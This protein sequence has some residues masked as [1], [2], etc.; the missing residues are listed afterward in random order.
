MKSTK[1]RAAKR[2][3][4]SAAP[5][6]DGAAPA[7]RD[8]PGAAGTPGASIGADLAAGETFFA[9]DQGLSDTPGA[10]GSHGAAIGAYLEARE[11]FLAAD[12]ALSTLLRIIQ[13]VAGHLADK[14]ERGRLIFH[15]TGIGLPW[16]QGA[17]LYA[18]PIMPG[19]WPDAARLQ[20]ALADWHAA[21]AGTRSAW[22]ALPPPFAAA[23]P[24]P[25]APLRT[26]VLPG[27]VTI[28]CL[29]DRPPRQITAIEE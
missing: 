1:Q 10:A 19:D 24:A 18:I 14:T 23:L 29:D 6:S 5:G 22:R 2:P 21:H 15:G 27:A 9:A 25:P 16:P 26:D 3:A 7:G 28:D 12:R 4:P 13:R 17:A 20:Q 8:R 11:T